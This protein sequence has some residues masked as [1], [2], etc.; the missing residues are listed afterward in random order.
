MVLFPDLQHLFWLPSA[1]Q[2]ILVVVPVICM[3]VLLSHVQAS[4]DF[5]LSFFEI[6]RC[7]GFSYR[8][9]GFAAND[10]SVL[11]GLYDT[12]GSPEWLESECW[13]TAREILYWSGVSVNT[14]ERVIK[15]DLS[16]SPGNRNKLTG[17]RL[18]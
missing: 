8:C 4:A 3:S 11:S 17:E 12:N 1:L 5:Q 13:K 15:L 18:E 14:E 10:S 7:D 9:A 2:H 16:G 6:M